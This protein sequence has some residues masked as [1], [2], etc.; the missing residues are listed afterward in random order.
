MLCLTVNKP[1]IGEN[2]SRKKGQNEW[3]VS[4]YSFQWII[5]IYHFIF[6]PVEWLK[7]LK[8]QRQRSKPFRLSSVNRKF[9]WI[10]SYWL[11]SVL[12]QRTDV[13]FKRIKTF[14]KALNDSIR[15]WA[16]VYWNKKTWLWQAIWGRSIR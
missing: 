16:Y 11:L 12:W 2:P 7:L 8:N 14:L 6:Q 9:T 4:N 1:Q 5:Y 10:L 15:I 3:L 13:T